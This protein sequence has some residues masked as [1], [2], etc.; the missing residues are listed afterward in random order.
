MSG[1]AKTLIAAGLLALV[2]TW[3]F[4]HRVLTS[5]YDLNPWEFF[6]W[7][8]YAT[9]RP[10]VVVSVLA[11]RGG[12]WQEIPQGVFPPPLAEIKVGY[13]IRRRQI[14][15]FQTPDPL[16]AAVFVQWP[17]LERV[18]IRSRRFVLDRRSGI[19]EPRDDWYLCGA[20][21]RCKPTAEPLR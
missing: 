10:T 18:A 9:P 5:R 4:V 15:K 17:S 12:K 11:P 14:G 19:F 1:R 16:A 7:A 20:A 3:P 8:M 2:G 6:G 13:E 21:E